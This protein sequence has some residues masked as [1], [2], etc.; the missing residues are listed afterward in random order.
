MMEL[1]VRSLLS[2]GIKF[3]NQGGTVTIGTMDEP[4]FTRVFVEDTGVG[5]PEEDKKKLFRLEYNY[6]TKGTQKEAEPGWGSCSAKSSSVF[7]VAT[8]GLTVR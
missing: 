4:D 6:S 7:T 8:S 5:I 1:I 3:T 2:N